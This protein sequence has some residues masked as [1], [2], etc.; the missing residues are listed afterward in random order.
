MMSNSLEGYPEYQEFLSALLTLKL[1]QVN[2]GKLKVCASRMIYKYSD[3]MTISFINRMKN[4]LG[5]GILLN[6]TW[7][8]FVKAFK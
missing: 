3:P 2:G 5:V 6:T 7:S 4:E 8:E 1:C